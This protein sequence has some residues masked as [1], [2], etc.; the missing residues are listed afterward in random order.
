LLYHPLG[1]LSDDPLLVDE[2]LMM[3]IGSAV[4]ARKPFVVNID[5]FQPTLSLNHPRLKPLQHPELG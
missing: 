4:D 2:P 1:L 3:R 5:Q